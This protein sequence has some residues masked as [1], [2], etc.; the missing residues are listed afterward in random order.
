[1]LHHYMMKQNRYNPQKINN[2]IQANFN[3]EVIAVPEE[4]CDYAT[5]VPLAQML[6]FSRVEF[7]KQISLATKSEVALTSKYPLVKLG[8]VCNILIGGT[9]SRSNSQYFTGH[10]LWVSIAEMQGNVIRDT[11][12]K[13]TDEAITHSNVKLI[14]AGT[15]LLSFKLS[16]GK[17]AIAGKDLYTNEA[18]AGLIP[19]NSDI[20]N[21]YLFHIFNAKVIDLDNQQLK[22]FGQSLNSKYLR[23]DVTIPLPPLDIQKQI[24]AECQAIDDL[25]LSA[26][27][28]KKY[29]E[30]KTSHVI[31]SLILQRKWKKLILGEVCD[32]LIGGT[33]SR[34]NSQYFTGRNLWVSIAEM[35]G[36]IITDTKEKI[37]NE[38]IANSNVKLIPAGTTL[39]SFKLSIGKTAIAGV[40]LY[41]NEAIAGLIPKNSDLLNNFLFYLFKTKSVSLDNQQWKIFGK[42]LNSKFLRENVQIPVPPLEVQQQLVSQIEVLEVEIAAAQAIIA[43]APAQKQAILHKYLD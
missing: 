13:I 25:T 12:E 34:N 33:P 20:L 43:A 40:D 6:D 8:E 1:M 31:E 38:A 19:K 36:N 23:E 28:N 2:L 10:N 3:G 7:N 11:K 26:E 4:L 9:P 41:T 17:T 37:T 27:Q 15:T 29:L 35:H 24:I 21:S 22:A 14:P 30:V 42:S 16:I 32:V 18:I 5:I 39:L